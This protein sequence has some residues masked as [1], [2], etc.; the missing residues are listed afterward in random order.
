[1]LL[2]VSFHAVN[3]FCF[4]EE[5]RDLVAFSRHDQSFDALIY[6]DNLFK[7]NQTVNSEFVDN[8]PVDNRQ[9]F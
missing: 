7:F 8:Q 3:V 2:S 6:R 9:M 4:G 5:N 1:M